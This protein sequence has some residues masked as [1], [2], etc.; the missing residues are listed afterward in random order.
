[1]NS[2]QGIAPQTIPR[3]IFKSSDFIWYGLGAA[4]LAMLFIVSRHNFLLFHGMAELFSIA[5]AWAVF[6]LVWNA[7]SYINNDALLL[8]G[9]A[10]L[11]IGFMDLLHTLAFKDMGFFP[12]AWSTN[13]PT[14]LWIAGRYMEGLALLLF[15][16]LLG[17]RIHPLIGLTFWAG[18]AAI[19]MGMIF[20]WC[21]FPDCHLESIGLTPF[22]I[23]S[24]YVICLVLL[25]AFGI[26][27]RKRAMLDAKVYR[28]MAGSMAASVAAELTFTTYLGSLIFPISSAIS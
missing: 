3:T 28:L 21:I 14:Q 23:W 6:M 22:K 11:F 8:L 1:M 20:F 24:E 25:A 12:D 13:L 10:Y 5:V 2:I 17:R 15:S 27:Y 26:L 9:S 19:L 18:L 4:T 16:L 7:R